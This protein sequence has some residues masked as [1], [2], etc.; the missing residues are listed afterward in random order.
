VI[1]I[2]LVCGIIQVA[3][4][5]LPVGSP[6]LSADTQGLTQSTAP[7][8][9][10]TPTAESITLVA[11]PTVTSASATSATAPSATGSDLVVST[12]FIEKEGEGT[13]VEG[14][15]S[16]LVRMPHGLY[17][18]FKTVDLTPGEAMTIWWAI[19]NKPEN[20]SDHVC[21]IDDVFLVDE[22]GNRLKDE[23]GAARPNLPARAATEFSLLRATGS[24]IDV[25]GRAEFR[26]HLPIADTQEVYFGPGLLNVMGSEVHL[27]LRT[28]GPAIPGGLYEQLNT[29]WG[30]CPAG[31]PKDPCG[32]LQIA[33][34]GA[35]E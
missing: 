23:E 9:P 31:W 25:D 24:V 26:A 29:D 33:I 1:V 3:C 28:H 2:T 35:A 20:C 17:M 5:N 10:P 22:E 34:H 16:T 11:T 30:G 8:Q 21:G 12:T 4:T 18:T 19:F 32:D 13:V 14:A 27:V 6:P 15:E 7:T